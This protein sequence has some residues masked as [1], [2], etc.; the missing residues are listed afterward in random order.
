MLSNWL[1]GI[2]HE[3]SDTL[4]IV[5]LVALYPTVAQFTNIMIF[6]ENS[7]TLVPPLIGG[8]AGTLVSA[9]ILFKKFRKHRES[10]KTE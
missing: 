10:P 7:F 3:I 5:V 6:D 8:L 9:T 4:R 1:G 2:K